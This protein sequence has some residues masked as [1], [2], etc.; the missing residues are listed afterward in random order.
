MKQVI[1]TFQ[2]ACSTIQVLLNANVFLSICDK[3]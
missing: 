2:G 3:W 1:L